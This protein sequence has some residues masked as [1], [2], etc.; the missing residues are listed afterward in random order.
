MA[1]A[2]AIDWT[3]LDKEIAAMGNAAQ[4]SFTIILPMKTETQGQQEHKSKCA[5]KNINETPLQPVSDNGE[6]EYFRK[7]LR[8]ESSVVVV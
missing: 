3:K 2:R 5:H 8:A 7:K 6:E 4:T 1:L